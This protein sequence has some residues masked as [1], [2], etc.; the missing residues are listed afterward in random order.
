MEEPVDAY[1]FGWSNFFNFLFFWTMS[2]AAKLI[3]FQPQT[4]TNVIKRELP[5]HNN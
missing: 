5:I 1:N 3:L 2:D 4:L